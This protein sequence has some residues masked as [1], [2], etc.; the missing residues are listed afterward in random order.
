MIR[1]FPDW[2]QGASARQVKIVK[3]GVKY[4]RYRR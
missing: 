3:K 2:Y 4:E 1:E